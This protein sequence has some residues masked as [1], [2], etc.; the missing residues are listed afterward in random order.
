MYHLSVLINK[1]RGISPSKNYSAL[2]LHQEQ[3]PQR[4]CHPDDNHQATSAMFVL[5]LM[6]RSETLVVLTLISSS[7]TFGAKILTIIKKL[8]NKIIKC[9]MIIYNL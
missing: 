1:N 3:D 4:H 5:I 6:I 2:H 9:N 7:E 8:Y